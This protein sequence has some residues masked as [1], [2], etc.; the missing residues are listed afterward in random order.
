MEEDVRNLSGRT[1]MAGSHCFTL[2]RAVQ[3]ASGHSNGVLIA[4]MSSHTCRGGRTCSW[5]SG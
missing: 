4:A 5:M 2:S 1:S 3:C